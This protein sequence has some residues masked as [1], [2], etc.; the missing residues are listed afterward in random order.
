M[1][2]QRDNRMKKEVPYSQNRGY[3]NDD[4]T[5]DLCGPI[6]DVIANLQRLKENGITRVDSHYYDYSHSEMHAFREETEEECSAREE[7]EAEEEANR[8]AEA[9]ERQR[10]KEERDRKQYEK[11]KAKFQ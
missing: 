6:D 2:Q 8:L 4:I 7:R 1:A 11:L 10:K 5:S 3:G 9:A